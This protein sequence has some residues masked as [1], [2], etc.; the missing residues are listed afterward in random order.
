MVASEIYD[1]SVEA[2]KTAS[3]ICRPA[4]AQDL[5]FLPS[6]LDM[7]MISHVF[8]PVI[9]LL[10]RLVQFRFSGVVQRFVR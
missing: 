5:L 8:Q 3:A 9:A 6:L 10:P 1:A 4:S 2:W 7:F